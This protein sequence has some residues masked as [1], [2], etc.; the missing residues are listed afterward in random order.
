MERYTGAPH[1][2]VENIEGKLV[3]AE[4]CQKEEDECE[5]SVSNKHKVRQAAAKMNIGKKFRPITKTDLIR[6]YQR[7][8]MP[9][10]KTI[11]D[12]KKYIENGIIP[13]EEKKSQNHTAISMPPVSHRTEK[14]DIYCLAVLKTCFTK[15]LCSYKGKTVAEVFIK[16]F[17]FLVVSA[18]FLFGIGYLLF[19]Y[20]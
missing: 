7:V 19:E 14:T 20:L 4:G 9:E 3:L 6:A 13:T 10:E 5:A 18:S 2:H 15:S 11:E 8:P 16:V 1:L 12:M 17:L